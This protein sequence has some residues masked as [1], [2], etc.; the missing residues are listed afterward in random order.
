[1]GN[2][3]IRDHLPRLVKA[4]ED[5]GKNVLWISDPVHGNTITAANGKKTRPVARIMDE[6]NGFF[7]VQ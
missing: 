2:E 1:M 4:V 6:I 7:E 3:N 5:A